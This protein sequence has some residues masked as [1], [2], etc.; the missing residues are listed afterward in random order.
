MRL[1]WIGFHKE[2]LPG[3]RALLEGGAP[4]KAVITLAREL[5]TARS[6]AAD[7]E[8]LCR[9]FH[10]PRY[11]VAD[12]NDGV[13]C[14]LLRSLTLDVVFVIGWS[15]ILEHATVETARWGMVR[16]RAAVVPKQRTS[17]ALQRAWIPGACAVANSLVW[18]SGEAS[19]GTPLDQMEF[20]ITPYDTS[21][22]L[23]ERVAASNRD[24]LLRLLP[25]LSAGAHAETGAAV[26]PA[27]P[28]APGAP[29]P[30]PGRPGGTG[31]R[32]K[33]SRHATP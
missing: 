5:A 8:P 24:M 11:E 33:R 1:G 22:S 20:V 15:Q 13:A 2:G 31:S 9:Y 27:D 4:V 25:Q 23:Y 10:V 18:L 19:T 32:S 14:E 29:G 12:I 17:A 6:G 26:A 16:T 3:L 28:A 21:A 30:H 7:Y